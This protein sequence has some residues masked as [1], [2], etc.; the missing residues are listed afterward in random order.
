MVLLVLLMRLLC[1][2]VEGLKV[3]LL[4]ES[5]YFH[6]FEIDGLNIT[7]RNRAEQSGNN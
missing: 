3:N 4:I 1:L 6:A 7:V 2:L 5:G